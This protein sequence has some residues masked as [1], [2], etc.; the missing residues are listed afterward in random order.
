MHFHRIQVKK[1]AAKTDHKT[2]CFVFVP[3]TVT[4]AAYAFRSY[5]K[6]RALKFDTL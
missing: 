3:S 6:P 2:F 1:T 4:T 5:M